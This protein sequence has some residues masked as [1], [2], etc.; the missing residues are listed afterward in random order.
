MALSTDADWIQLLMNRLGQR[1]GTTL[2]AKVVDEINASIEEIEKG[3][4][5]PWFLETENTEVTV[6]STRTI[7]LPTGF[8]REIENRSIQIL[9]G[10]SKWQLLK[11][12]R[13][14]DLDS[15]FRNA[16]EGRPTRY[17]LSGLNIFVG[18]TPNDV[19]TI[20][21]P[22]MKATT[23]IT[24]SG[25]AATNPWLT[26]AHNWILSHAGVT[27]ASLQ[28]QNQKLAGVFGSVAARAR[29]E[30]MNSHEAREHTNHQY[31]DV[32]RL[33]G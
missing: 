31:S 27:V 28:L 22:Y 10:D 12:L 11:K 30:L 6:A 1:T 32:D 5:L 26:N 33:V 19:Y 9:D 24:D 21:F 15:Q 13:I 3:S 4:F 20:D 8:L 7:A 17:A 18:R 14:E 23:A 25:A 29:Q 2:R 16:S